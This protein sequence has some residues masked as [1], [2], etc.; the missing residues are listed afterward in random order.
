MGSMSKHNEEK[1]REE[2][3]EE[4]AKAADQSPRAR[5]QPVGRVVKF[6]GVLV[7]SVCKQHRSVCTLDVSWV[8]EHLKSKTEHVVARRPVIL[9]WVVVIQIQGSV[10]VGVWNTGNVPEDEHE[11]KLLVCHVPGWNNKLFT[12][13]ACVGVQIVCQEHEPGLGG[14]LAVFLVLFKAQAIGEEEQR[15]PR[16]SD[17]EEHLEVDDSNSWVE[18]SP[19][20]NVVDRVTGHSEI[21][22]GDV[23]SVEVQQNGERDTREDGAGHDL[24]KVVNDVVDLE[25]VE[26]V[27]H[28]HHDEVDV[29]G[30]VSVA[31]VWQL[32]TISVRKRLAF[33][34]D[35]G[36]S[37]VEDGL[38]E[39]VR[40]EHKHGEEGRV[41][42]GFDVANQ[43]FKELRPRLVLGGPRWRPM[44]ESSR[45]PHVV[46]QGRETGHHSQ[47]TKRATELPL[48]LI[49]GDA[50]LDK[51]RR[52]CGVF[53]TS[54]RYGL[55]SSLRSLKLVSS[56]TSKAV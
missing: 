30:D 33:C 24:T 9:L 26:V 46:H 20:E 12:L 49:F 55:S 15:V 56:A 23:E 44:V 41:C 14:D 53:L 10:A 17:L 39:D 25:D 43:E 48:D 29:E 27:Q 8:L 47:G 6:S 4:R 42:V 37:D 52:P 28:R 18:W 54:P 2:P 34:P 31:K 16:E 19:H 32:L 13:G 35:A 36:Q 21:I 38:E 40:E 1:D 5:L 51:I 45:D 3:R 50:S 22:L 11:S 7:P